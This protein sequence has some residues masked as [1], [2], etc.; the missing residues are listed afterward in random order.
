MDRTEALIS[1]QIGG[2]SRGYRGESITLRDHCQL[3][4]HDACG[5]VRVRCAVFGGGEG[6]G[7]ALARSRTLWPARGGPAY[8]T[9]AVT[10]LFGTGVIRDQSSWIGEL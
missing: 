4:M 6:P 9:V 5:A 7:S 2:Y 10:G 3:R 1:V 8:F